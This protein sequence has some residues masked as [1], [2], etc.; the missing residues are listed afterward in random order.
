MRIYLFHCCQRRPFG[1]R[2]RNL[3]SIQTSSSTLLPPDKLEAHPP[4]L[5]PPAS[6]LSHVPLH[7]AP[8]IHFI[9]LFFTGPSERE[10]G[11][12]GI[13]RV[14]AP[15]PFT[16]TVAWSRFDFTLSPFHS[17]RGRGNTGREEGDNSS[18]FLAMVPP[19]PP[20]PPP[21]PESQPV[22]MKFPV[23][24]LTSDLMALLF[25]RVARIEVLDLG[26][27]LC[28]RYLITVKLRGPG[29]PRW[30]PGLWELKPTRP[31]GT[32]GSPPAPVTAAPAHLETKGATGP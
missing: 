30:P 1:A 15:S 14:A 19:P 11:S 4:T 22:Q 25:P 27:Q 6:P 8:V 2:S 20:P 17:E 32:K 5:P 7:L 13:E 31:A 23:P 24:A 10:E 26:P 3:N 29:P 12:K 18:S 28:K 16:S 21:P 9:C